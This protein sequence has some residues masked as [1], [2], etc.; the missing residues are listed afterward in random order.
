MLALPL[1]AL[2]ACTPAALVATAPDADAA[3]AIAGSRPWAA[4]RVVLAST[5]DWNVYSAQGWGRQILIHVPDTA[6]ASV[7]V[8]NYDETGTY[9]ATDDQITLAAG[10]SLVLPLTAGASTGPSDHYA[11]PLAS[12]EAS[13]V[14]E[15]LVVET[16]Q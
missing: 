1:L 6:A 4:D 12:T 2:A 3:T 9:D 16:A 10:A 7:H 14:V 15:L 5:T 11:I 8:G 13:A